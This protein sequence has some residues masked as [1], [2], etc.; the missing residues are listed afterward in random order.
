[1]SKG[2]EGEG[3]GFSRHTKDDKKVNYCYFFSAGHKIHIN[4]EYLLFTKIFNFFHFVSLP[5][6]VKW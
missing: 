3:S 4:T 6:L 5:D 1:M 2:G